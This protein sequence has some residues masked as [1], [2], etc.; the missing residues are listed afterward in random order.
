MGV[1]SL[2]IHVTGWMGVISDNTCYWVNGG[3]LSDNACYWVNGGHLSDYTC[4]WVY[5]RE[6]PEMAVM[7]VVRSR[8]V[9]LLDMTFII[10]TLVI[11]LTLQ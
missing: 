8:C 5:E 9:V 7:E 6:H 1:I 2:T 10:L 11:I 3:H 4:Y